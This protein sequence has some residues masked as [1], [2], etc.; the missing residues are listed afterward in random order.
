MTNQG[1]TPR[2]PGYGRN[3]PCFCGSGQKFKR[4]HGRELQQRQQA[5]FASARGRF[6]GT[7]KQKARCCFIVEP[8]P[9]KAEA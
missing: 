2:A 1:T 9:E 5:M 7:P 3:D 8:A 4:C 6:R